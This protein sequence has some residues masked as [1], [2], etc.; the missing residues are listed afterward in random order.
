MTRKRKNGKGSKWIRPATRLAIYARDGFAC[1]VCARGAE[2][3]S[4]TLDHVVALDNG[5]THAATNLVTMC[6][7]CNS[8][9]QAKRV[10]SWFAYLRARDVN[11]SALAK[12]IK[13]RTSKP[14]DRAE[15]RRL[16]E[17]RRARREVHA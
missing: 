11:T 3:V 7:A 15:G 12:R 17:L 6:F 14:I 4:L 9:K 13:R 2:D 16:F 1:V 5:G 10:R 8:R